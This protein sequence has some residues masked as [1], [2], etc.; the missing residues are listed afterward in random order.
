L[1]EPI[2]Y[3]DRRKVKGYTRKDGRS[4]APY[5]RSYWVVAFPVPLE[6]LDLRRFGRE[7][8]KTAEKPSAGKLT[9]KGAGIRPFKSS[10][11]KELW[12]PLPDFVEHLRKEY[13][14]LSID[15]EL[16]R[17]D[18]FTD[19]VSGADGLIWD[20][21]LKRRAMKEIG[22]SVI[23]LVKAWVLTYNMNAEEYKIISWYRSLEVLDTEYHWK[24]RKRKRSYIDTVTGHKG[25]RFRAES[26][27]DAYEV[28]RDIYD[29]MVERFKTVDYVHILRVVGW[30]F[31]TN[32]ALEDDRGRARFFKQ[33]K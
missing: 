2:S 12:M 7:L 11:A 13:E 29:A 27:A 14:N 33:D 32:R 24:G 5:F 16:Y 15:D 17:K 25:G 26:F 9:V 20:R 10:K 28:V 8:E 30:S 21:R 19:V 31:W 6:S 1:K 22:A 23:G 18:R 4:I 3:L